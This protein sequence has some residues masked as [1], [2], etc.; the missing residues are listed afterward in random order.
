MNRL[1]LA[2]ALAFALATAAFAAEVSFTSCTA[3]KQAVTVDTVLDDQAV[4][5]HPVIN[6]VRAAFNSAAQSLSAA[7][8]QSGAGYYAF[9]SYLDETDLAAITS[10]RTPSVIGSC[11]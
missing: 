5:R 11:N 3:D 10:I 9:V 6:H 2:V 1:F 7:D 8:L 4:A